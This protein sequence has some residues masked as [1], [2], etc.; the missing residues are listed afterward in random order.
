MK[1]RK[2]MFIKEP[3]INPIFGGQCLMIAISSIFDGDQVEDQIS[4]LVA[5]V[6]NL[7]VLVV[8]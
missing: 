7:F 2:E 3:S 1:H 6:A 5:F 4:A 8:D